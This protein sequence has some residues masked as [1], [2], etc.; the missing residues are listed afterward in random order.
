M[1][2]VRVQ[3]WQSEELSFEFIAQEQLKDAEQRRAS[4]ET[5]EFAPGKELQPAGWGVG[6]A[7][8]AL[9]HS[10]SAPAGLSSK[11]NVNAQLQQAMNIAHRMAIQQAAARAAALSNASSNGS[12]AIGSGGPHKR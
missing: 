7:G 4:R 6:L 3:E 12:S 9:V 2:A 5:I 11:I 1:V 10:A 8:G